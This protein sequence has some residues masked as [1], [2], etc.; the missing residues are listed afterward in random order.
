MILLVVTCFIVDKIFTI[1][2][3]ELFLLISVSMI[4]VWDFC[5]KKSRLKE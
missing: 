3:H 4:L 2:L 5:F 1:K